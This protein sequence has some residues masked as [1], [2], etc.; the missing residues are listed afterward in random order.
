MQVE[1]ERGRP[2]GRGTHQ[3]RRI[4]GEKRAGAEGAARPFGRTGRDVGKV[5]A[6]DQRPADIGMH[7]TGDAAQPG[8]DGV[9]RLH[10]AS[11][12]LAA[13]SPGE[14][15]GLIG[16]LGPALAHQYE[17]GRVGA[18]GDGRAVRLGQRPLDIALHQRGILIHIAAGCAEDLG[19]E[20][21]LELAPAPAIGAQFA[22]R[23][24]LVLRDEARGEA[25]RH[26]HSVMHLGHDRESGG[27]HHSRKRRQ[28]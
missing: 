4:R 24:M 9:H 15:A 23:H 27:P 6:V 8:F 7:M 20:A 19:P 28:A 22:N 21:A 3:R 10:P 12:A 11:K 1:P 13:D 14:A 2:G 17:D 25:M 16:E 18:E 26:R 5:Q